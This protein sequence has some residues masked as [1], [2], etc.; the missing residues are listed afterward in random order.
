MVGELERSGVLSRE[1]I[2]VVA[3]LDDFMNVPI[4]CLRSLI[5]CGALYSATPY[6]RSTRNAS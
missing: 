2:E 5:I 1:A 6:W 4:V 3:S